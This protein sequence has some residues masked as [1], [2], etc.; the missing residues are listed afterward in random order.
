MAKKQKIVSIILILFFTIFQIIPVIRNGIK[1][2]YGIGFW[3]SNGH[4]AIWHLS[5]INNIH[6]PFEINMPIFS[7]ENLKNY[8]PFFDILISFLTNITYISSSI[9]LFQIIPI[10]TAFLTIYISFLLGKKITNKFS[11]GIY[12]AFLTTFANSFGWIVSLFKNGNF[13]GESMFWSMQSISNQLNPPYALSILF[14]SII[15]LIIF[16]NKKL[17]KSKSLILIVLLSILPVTKAYGAVAIFIFFGLFSLYSFFKKNYTPTIILITSL[18]IGF[19]LFSIFN[20]S[21]DKLFI[22]KP[23]WFTNTLFEAPDRLYS[24]QITNL[25]Y[26]LESTGQISPKLLLIYSFGI[27]VFLIGNYSWRLFGL[28]TLKDKNPILKQ[29]FLTIILITLIPLLFVQKGTSWNTIQFL[30]YGLFLSNIFSAL[31]LT[32]IESKTLGKILITIILLTSFI[33]SFSTIKTFLKNPSHA[34][35]SN[36]E[37][38]GLKKLSTLTTGNIL[39]FPYDKYKKNSIKSDPVPLYMYETTAY[40]S[41]FSEKP[42][43][44]EDEMNLIIT[45]YDW[46][47]RR[48]EAEKFFNTEDKFFAR[49]FLLNNKIDYIYLVDDQSF[50]VSINDLGIDKIFENSQTRIYKVRR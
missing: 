28:F 17:S 42:V 25:R 35:I 45:G 21:S 20:T 5:L 50:K 10:I 2:N 46:Q 22:Y 13:S 47:S 43:Y 9:W 24:S 11:G 18:I 19:S 32:K 44:L 26:T 33:S 3:G 1:Y 4:D 34:Y 14:I 23:L 37:L 39:T 12:L 38:E 15:L 36:Q 41:A 30:Y 40:V 16:K 29:L 49:G 6:N 27:I 31:F 7:G 8:H 48:K